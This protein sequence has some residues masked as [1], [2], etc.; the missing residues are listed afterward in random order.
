[1]FILLPNK[2]VF[3]MHFNFYAILVA[4]IVP[5]VLGFIWYHPKV[6]GNAWMQASSLTEEKIRAANMPLILGLSFV[7]AFM[8]SFV[9]NMLVI[10]QLHVYSLFQHFDKDVANPNTR[11]G[12]LVKDIMDNFGQEFRTFKHGA[13][14]GFMSA[15][16]IVFPVMA[17]NA[18][19]ERKSWKYIWI[20]FGFWAIAFL[21][22]GGIISAWQ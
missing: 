14:H 15:L 13:L 16:F 8:L 10:H 4:S 18:M 12:A 17:T 2:N 7:F 3:D 20:N 9:M 19:Y 11:V 22:M 1:M 6:M 5:M 21:I